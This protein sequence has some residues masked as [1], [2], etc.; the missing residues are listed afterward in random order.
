M[1]ELLILLQRE[2]NILANDFEMLLGSDPLLEVIGRA[3]ILGLSGLGRLGGAI[4]ENKG[5]S[6]DNWSKRPIIFSYV[7]GF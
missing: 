4:N 7:K 5:Y 6:M 1:C 3:R 2:D